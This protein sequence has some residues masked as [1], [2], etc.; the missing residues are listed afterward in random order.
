M[1]KKYTAIILSKQSDRT[2]RTGVGRF[3]YVHLDEAYAQNPQDKPKYSLTFMFDKND[4]QALKVLEEA[5]ENATQKGIEK[6]GKSF[7]GKKFHNPINDGDEKE[8]EEYEGF[9]YMNIKNTHRPVC[10]DQKREEMS[11]EDIYSGCYGRCV[12]EFYPFNRA[13]N[14]GVAASLKSVQFLGDGKPL[15]G[16]VK[17]TAEDFDD[18]NDGADDGM[19]D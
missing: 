16:G 6:F 18:D 10:Y 13:G 12:V 3:A 14:T 5:I 4:K 8:D 2:V 7:N 11:A 9:Y 17:S 19:L 1:E 15:A